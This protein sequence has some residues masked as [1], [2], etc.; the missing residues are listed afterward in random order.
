VHSVVFSPDGQTLASGSGDGTLQLWSLETG[1]QVRTLRSDRLYEGMNIRGTTG[2]TD[3]QKMALK[4]LGAVEEE[5]G[6]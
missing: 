2:L 4:T 1:A 6:D 5:A 3:A